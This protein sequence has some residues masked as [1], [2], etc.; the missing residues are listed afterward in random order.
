MCVLKPL[1]QVQKYSFSYPGEDQE[2]LQN[3]SFEIDKPEIILLAGDSG[4]GDN[5]IMMIV[6]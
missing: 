4:S 1:I 5:A 2:A 3:I 6:Q